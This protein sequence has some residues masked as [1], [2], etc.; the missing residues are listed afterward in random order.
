VLVIEDARDQAELCADVCAQAGLNTMTAAT[1]IQG[2]HK[3]CGMEPGVIVLDLALP[4]VDGWDVCR[5]LK[6][7]ARTR[8]IPIVILT[9]RD[10][11]GNIER[12]AQE[13]AVAYLKKPCPPA[14]L[15]AAIK[16]VLWE[17]ERSE[18]AV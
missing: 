6:V 9:A 14:D 10:E 17:G 5:R 11:P 1:G 8:D 13:G 3:A 15:V 16:R 7:D 12:A 2:Y 4:D 18:S